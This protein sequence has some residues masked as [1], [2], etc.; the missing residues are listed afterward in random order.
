MKTL[1]FS[2]VR[3]PRIKELDKPKAGVLTYV[4]DPTEEELQEL[5]EIHGLDI[6][7]LNDG[8]D[9]NEAP[10]IEKL[11]GRVYIYSRFVLKE[12][13]KGTTSPIL[14]IFGLDMVYV[15]TKKS[16]TDFKKLINRDDIITSMRAKLLLQILGTVN[17]GYMQRIN[18]IGKRI[19]G[20]RAQL[21]KAH[22]DNKVFVAV[23]DI[24]EAINDILLALD[25]M[26]TLLNSLLTGK[27]I[28]LYE[29]DQDLVED[30]ELSS[31]ELSRIASSQLMTLKNIREAY[32]TM[33]ANNLNKV[34][35]LMTSITILMGI[36][37][38]ITGIYSMNIALPAEN[39]PNAFWI[40][41]GVTSAFIGFASYLFKKNK[42]F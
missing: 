9:P 7:L 39:S 21:D 36:F 30:L 40:I 8:L 20:M 1:Y 23:I 4:E 35:K 3:S 10:R 15:V 19:N 38:L 18:T 22:I 5:V 42:W 28:K 6:D 17:S 31:D 33:M 27:I 2:T 25:P 26:N 14:I 16:F 41:L 13:E 12:E 11:D 29:E 24:E 34:F 32:S 37:T